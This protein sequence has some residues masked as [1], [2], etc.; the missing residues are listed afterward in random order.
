MK[1]LNMLIEVGKFYKQR[2][3]GKAR[4]IAYNGDAL[5][6]H[7]FVG[8]DCYNNVC[9]WAINGNVY[10]LREDFCDLVSEWEQPKQ[11]DVYYQAVTGSKD[12]FYV[13][14][15]LSQTQQ[16]L[17]IWALAERNSHIVYARLL[18]DRPIE[19]EE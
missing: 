9:A 2:N 15:R 10:D 8:W 16:E 6:T 14:T 1:V 19:V 11:K 17:A 13:S 5:D 4:V 3:G 12:H 18:T 7:Q